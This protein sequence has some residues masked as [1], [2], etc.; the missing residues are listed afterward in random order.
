M[1]SVRDD[2]GLRLAWGWV[3]HLRSGGTTPWLAWRETGT[4]GEP[5]VRAAVHALP[6]AQ[7]LELL[8][9][10]NQ[11]GTPGPTLAA[12]VLQGSA[13][14]RGRPDLELVGVAEPSAFGL[15]PVDPAGLPRTEL[16]RVATWLLADDVV[17]AGVP[18]APRGI[19]RP[20]RRRYRIVGDPWVAAAAR[21]DLARRGRP[22][23][24]HPAGV[25][26]VLG[27]DV[28]TMIADVWVTRA[29][30][31]GVEEW[32]DFVQAFRRRRHLPPRADLVGQARW[33][34]ERIGPERVRIVLDPAELPRLAG[35]RRR[36]ATPPRLSADAAELCRR[37]AP[38][39]GVLAL[40]HQRAD[41][42]RRQ[43]APRLAALD[44][45]GP[46][47]GVPE[48]FHRWLGRMATRQ[49]EGLLAAGYAVHGDPDLLLPPPAGTRTGAVPSVDGVF[50]LAL[51][52]L[53]EGPG[54]G[55]RGR[56]G[57]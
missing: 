22:E 42:L 23:G 20:W 25:T 56:G 51:R 30:S 26:L 29:C 44:P 33:W 27:R 35:V 5:P 9:T 38:V 55:S 41:L 7:Q 45:G 40:P 15:P 36:L 47:L 16:L 12:R 39:L 49:R 32:E 28:E 17:A 57:E 18:D 2:Q 4:P 10:L 19:V 11:R 34:A 43:V 8:R 13:P 37:L 50:E 52:L 24:D 46:P 1:S 53:I 6:G 14:G 3:A 21:D 54:R 31:D 48:R